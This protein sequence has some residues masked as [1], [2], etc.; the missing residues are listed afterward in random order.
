MVESFGKCDAADLAVFLVGAPSG[1]CEVAT[2]NAFDFERIELFDR[3]AAK[4]VALTEF[5]A[6]G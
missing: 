6:L 4:A 5:E 3:H 1:S 2:D